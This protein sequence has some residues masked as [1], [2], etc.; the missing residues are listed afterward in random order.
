MMRDNEE[1]G[2]IKLPDRR[3][4]MCYSAKNGIWQI[5]QMIAPIRNGVYVETNYFLTLFITF[6]FHVN[7][8]VEYMITW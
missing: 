7:D 6:T 5:G 4:A 3:E 1:R 8:D 2:M